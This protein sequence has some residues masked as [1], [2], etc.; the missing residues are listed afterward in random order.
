M[1]PWHGLPWPDLTEARSTAADTPAEAGQSQHLGI[2]ELLRV[3][4]NPPAENLVFQGG[5]QPY[6]GQENSPTRELCISE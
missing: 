3:Q 5:T 2:Q 1:S 4:D 6:T